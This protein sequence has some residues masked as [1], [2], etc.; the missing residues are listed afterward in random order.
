MIL[1]FLVA[2]DLEIP[3]YDR[4]RSFELMSSI[5]DKVSHYFYIVSHGF[6]DLS[7]EKSCHIPKRYQYNDIK[8]QE[9]DDISHKIIELISFALKYDCLMSWAIWVCHLLDEVS[10]K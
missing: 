2:Q 9:T 10:T 8:S 7:H 4:K 5:M 1:G 6:Q 3:R